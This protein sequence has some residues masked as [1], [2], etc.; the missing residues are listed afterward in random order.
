[1]TVYV[2]TKRTVWQVV[3]PGL[4]VLL[5]LRDNGDVSV[6]ST[7]GVGGVNLQVILEKRTDP[8]I[9]NDDGFPFA[10][11]LTTAIP[12][13]V[14]V[15]KSTGVSSEIERYSEFVLGTSSAPGRFGTDIPV[16]VLWRM[17]QSQR[18]THDTRLRFLVKHEQVSTVYDEEMEGYVSTPQDQWI[19]ATLRG[20]T[21]LTP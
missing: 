12:V 6:P 1:M 8:T 3:P 14:D 21:Q 2:E 4:E 19:K 15:N 5:Q 17:P 10:T 11:R 16:S 7:L 18:S 20:F 13:L 9:L